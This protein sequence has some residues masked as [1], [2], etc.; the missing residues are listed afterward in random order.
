MSTHASASP[1][2]PTDRG[3]AAQ[4]VPLTRRVRAGLAIAALLGAGDL[5][6]IAFQTPAGQVGPP[7]GILLLAAALGVVTLV[8]VVVAWRSNSRGAIRVVAGA[9][10]LSALG[11]VPAFFAGPPPLLVL[12]ASV[13]V[14]LTV[15]SIIL[16]LSPAARPAAV[17]D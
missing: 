4:Q 1:T 7:L 11:A 10:L 16:M 9:R 14:I 17:T 13:M 2:A 15:V 12:L 5:V 6:G 3:A 8:G